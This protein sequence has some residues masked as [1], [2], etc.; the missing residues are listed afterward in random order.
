[1]KANTVLTSDQL[2]KQAP[3]LDWD[4]FLTAA[5]LAGQQRF[6]VWQSTAITG[7]S[8]LT[9]TQSIETWRDYLAFHTVAR[10]APFLSKAFV[11]ESFAFNGQ[12]LSGTPAQRERWKRGVDATSDALGEA[13]GKL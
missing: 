9:V 8:S 2:R 7:L 11:D 5:G 3:G 4:V 6:G 1:M 10:G 13:I 12:A